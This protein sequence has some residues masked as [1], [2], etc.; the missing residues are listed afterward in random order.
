MSTNQG[1]D[2]KRAF[3]L[4]RSSIYESLARG[5]VETFKRCADI[6]ITKGAALSDVSHSVLLTALL[7]RRRVLSISIGV[8]IHLM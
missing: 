4:R 6:E 5:T 8:P 3:A 2:G 7:E 1:S